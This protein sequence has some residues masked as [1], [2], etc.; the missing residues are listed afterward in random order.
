MRACVVPLLIAAA[1]ATTA[2]LG[3]PP[4]TH[5]RWKD[6]AGVV[7]FGDT[8]PASALANGYEVVNDQGRVVRRVD[9]VLTP[10]ERRAVA[11][12]QARREAAA[13]ASQQQSLSD[14]QLLAAYPTERDLATAQ[15]AQIA[16]I[17]T[18]I[19]ALQGNLDSQESALSDLLAHAADL[20]HTKQPIPVTLHQ[21]IGQQR[22][23]VNSERSALV[24]RRADLANAELTFAAQLQHYRT[25]RA[26]FSG[27]ADDDPGAA[28]PDPS[29]RR[30]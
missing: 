5:Y 18:D 25:L 26:K 29:S 21:R 11:A 9:R 15:H 17:N 3:A 7:H 1:L 24:R 12:A 16:Q 10:S 28:P 13:R 30:P 14:A 4:T 20:E 2:A 23:I 6:A 27:A 22:G 19:T 8:I